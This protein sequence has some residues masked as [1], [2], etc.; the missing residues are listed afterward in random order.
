M[1]AAFTIWVLGNG[2]DVSSTFIEPAVV[3]RIERSSLKIA[4]STIAAAVMV[5]IAVIALVVANSPLYE[6]VK[7][8][9]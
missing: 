2:E 3:R 1:A 6:V 7:E 8:I 4:N 9:P 5:L